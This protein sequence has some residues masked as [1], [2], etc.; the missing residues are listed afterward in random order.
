MVSP[1][2]PSSHLEALDALDAAA[3]P[4]VATVPA[5]WQTRL[6]ARA[7][8]AQFA[9]VCARAGIELDPSAGADL[10]VEHAELFARIADG[11]WVG[12]AEG[13]MAGE[14]RAD[15][16]VDVLAALLEA[17]YRP[18]G[19]ATGPGRASGGDV[20]PDL[21]QHYAGDGM[22]A[23]AGHFATGVA[24][25]QREMVASH[26]P[27]AGRG[28]EPASHFVDV[29]RIEAP[30]ATERVDL[31]NAQQRTVEMLLGAGAVGAGTHLVEYPASGGA[32][33]I[34]AAQRR[35]TVDCITADAAVARGI[36]ER[37]TFAGVTG[38]VR[39]EAD[40]DAGLRR[41]GYYDAAV[42]VEKLETFGPRE[43]GAYLAALGTLI[44][45]GGRAALQTVTRTEKYS[46]AADAA[47]DS[48]RAYVWPGLSFSTPEEIARVVDRETG[49]RVIAETHAPQHL[50]RSLRLQRETFDAHLRE[51]AADGFDAV[52][53]RLWRW[54]F[55]L[56]E[57]LARL[58]M[59]DLVQ[60]TL[61]QR[62]RRGRR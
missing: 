40:V 33:A 53:R 9:R 29:T 23:F 62:S 19:R 49:L 13:Y 38:A 22:S 52:Y 1:R 12:L 26:V 46:P 43:K 55:A 50:E 25:T 31:A 37:I 32:V 10:V 14:W 20:P 39:V 28:S 16:L 59:T 8:E 7:A 2:V 3:W 60:L 21:V 36:D 4:G 27:G 57:A 18:R 56:R 11:G 51:A 6:R 54:Q 44:H 47:L 5:G 17:G 15:S 30:L 24:T 41:R 48:L 42:G 58:G 61:V 34:A 35:A 45:P